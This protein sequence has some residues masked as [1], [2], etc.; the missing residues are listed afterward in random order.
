MSDE[1]PKLHL[2]NT[3]GDPDLDMRGLRMW[4]LETAAMVVTPG[5]RWDEKVLR[6]AQRF[7]DY[8]LVGERK[9]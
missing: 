8:V 7:L 6:T 4:A 5:P 3:D 2:I 1:P 9:E